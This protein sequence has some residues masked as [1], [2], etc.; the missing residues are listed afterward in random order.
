[1]RFKKIS[2]L[3]GYAA[4]LLKKY[5]DQQNI[6]R[7]VEIKQ[8]S[9]C[10]YKLAIQIIGKSTVVECT[11]HEIVANDQM[12]EGFSKKD[13]RAITF[14]AC[15]QSKKP[16]YKVVMQEFCDTF[17]KILFKLKKHDSDE[18]VL[19]TA[20]QISLDKNLINDLSQE[21]ACSIS[22]TA[23]LNNHFLKNMQM[24]LQQ[25]HNRIF[26]LSK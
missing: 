26:R 10:H 7:V 23:G 3:F 21:D 20:G 25:N 22:Y 24:K 4:W 9:G 8:S 5:S 1:M 6:Y 13:I 17:N 16:K 12:L 14:F 11:P 15:E 18:I 2:S 19:K